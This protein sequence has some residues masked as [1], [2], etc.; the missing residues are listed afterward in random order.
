ME[1]GLVSPLHQQRVA[2]RLHKINRRCTLGYGISGT[3]TEAFTRFNSTQPD[4]T[5]LS[6]TLATMRPLQLSLRPRLQTLGW[7]SVTSR[8]ATSRA[9]HSGAVKPDPRWFTKLQDRLMPITGQMLS[10]DQK[11]KKDHILDTMRNTWLCLLAGPE[12]FLTDDRW[13]GLNGHEVAW[14][15]MVSAAR[16]HEFVLTIS[17]QCRT[18]W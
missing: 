1:I 5:M 17:T 9:S 16:W 12:G 15:D 8:C 2:Q 6:S 10:L 7:H 14:G 11:K 13:K 4:A 18:L 3:I